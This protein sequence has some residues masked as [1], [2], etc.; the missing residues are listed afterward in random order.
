MREEKRPIEREGER[1]EGRERFSHTGTAAVL[2]IPIH[3]TVSLPGNPRTAQR[4]KFNTAPLQAQ[5]APLATFHTRATFVSETFREGSDSCGH[6][7]C[8]LAECTGY[9]L[10]VVD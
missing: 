1:E 2:L 9:T 3:L 4:A 7:A 5:E 10:L 6:T 8:I